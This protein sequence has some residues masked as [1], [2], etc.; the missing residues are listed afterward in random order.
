MVTVRTVISVAA[1]KNWPVF[2]MD[3]NNAF[4]QE[5]L[6]EDVYMDLPRDALQEAGYL[7]SPYD[8]SLFTRK[9]NDKIVIVLVYVDGLLITGNSGRL[10]EQVKNTLHINLKVKDL[11]E[12]RY[13]LG[14]EVLRSKNGILLNQRKYALELISDVSLSDAKPVNTPLEVNTM[15][16]IIDYDEHVGGVNDPMLTDI[17]SYQKLV[18][19]LLYLTIT[20]PDI[21]FD[22]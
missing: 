15:L 20:R 10:I 4:L 16:T 9:E 2:Q 14:I 17:T 3:V 12:L 8:H 11:G 1:S 13:F 18:G 7:Q 5:D 21:G 6:Q 19:K 22:V